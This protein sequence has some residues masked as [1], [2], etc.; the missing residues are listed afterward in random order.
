MYRGFTTIPQRV[1]K[2]EY[3]GLEIVNYG[4]QNAYPQEADYAI[5][6]CSIADS[7]CD[8]LSE[9]TRGNGFADESLNLTVVNSDG[10]TLFDILKM[11]SKDYSRFNGYALHF[12]YN[13]LGEIVSIHHVPFTYCRLG[14][15]DPETLRSNTIRVWDNWANESIKQNNSQALIK[16]YCRYN[17]TSVL[18]EIKACGGIGKYN[19][20]ILYWTNENDD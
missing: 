4:I 8:V 5:S 3:R 12:N 18:D 6:G 1:Y 7:C 14:L 20:Q 16:T 17:P 19:G 9:F 2:K 15:P 11:V 10:Q 13:L